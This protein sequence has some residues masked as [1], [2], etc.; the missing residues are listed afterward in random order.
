MQVAERSQLCGE[1]EAK[2][3]AEAFRAMLSK[4]GL[5]AQED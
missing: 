2:Q 1:Q 5:H 4:P 3:P